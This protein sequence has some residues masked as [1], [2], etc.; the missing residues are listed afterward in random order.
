MFNSLRSK[1]VSVQAERMIFLA[2][3]NPLNSV[4]SCEREVPW[5][6]T[7][8]AKREIVVQLEV[9]KSYGFG[10]FIIHLYD[11]FSHAMKK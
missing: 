4:L 6:S 1:V 8:L 5:I 7:L 3:H 2:S 11:K 9:R 10:C